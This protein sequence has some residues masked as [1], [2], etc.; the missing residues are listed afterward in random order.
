MSN[1]LTQQVSLGVVLTNYNH[2]SLIRRALT[3]LTQQER[4][5][6]QLIIVDDG[7]R[8]G[9]IE[10]IR[11]FLK[12]PRITLI[13]KKKNEGLAKAV[14]SGLDALQTDLVYFAAA[15]D[16][17]YPKFFQRASH[18]AA[19]H[20]EAA[21][22]FGR[23]I[24]ISWPHST[25]SR[26]GLEDGG[27]PDG[28]GLLTQQD[29]FTRYYCKLGPMSNLSPATIYR[30]WALEAIRYKDLLKDD[31]GF[32]LDSFIVQIIGG[33]YPSYYIDADCVAWTWSKG[34]AKQFF[35]DNARLLK[36]VIGA[37][38][39]LQQEPYTSSLT[40]AH[41]GLYL[42][43]LWYR[44]IQAGF[45]FSPIEFKSIPR[46]ITAL[47][48]AYDIVSK[49]Y[50]A[51]SP[52]TPPL[53]RLVWRVLLGVPKIV[54]GISCRVYQ[55]LRKTVRREFAKRMLHVFIRPHKGGTSSPQTTRISS[56]RLAPVPVAKAEH[57]TISAL[58]CNFNHAKHI[59]SSIEAVIAQT[60]TPDELL[61]MDD[62]STDGSF[63]IM[64]QYVDKYS[65][66]R[67]FK[68]ERNMGYI[69]GISELTRIAKG[70]FIHRGTSDDYMEPYF[71]EKTMEMAERFPTVGVVSTELN[72]F[73]EL[74][75]HMSILEVPWW[76]TGYKSPDEFLH[77]C[78]E[79]TDP[80]AT[81][82]PSTIFRK[83]VVDEV[84]GWREELD[85][86]DVSFV[87]QAAALKYGM[88]YVDVPAYTWVARTRGWTQETNSDVIKAASVCHSYFELM[89]SP[90]FR[91]LFGDIFPE[92]WLR[93]NLQNITDSVFSRI[94]QGVPA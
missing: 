52:H 69:S 33:R 57:K 10:A 84:G 8:D 23:L 88:V 2:G 15:D 6:D 76:G 42:Y 14:L 1:S 30:T 70:E 75:A 45:V 47:A 32:I 21:M 85:T 64:K 81:L 72:V 87:L 48:E 31:F 35:E 79:V 60:R 40:P 92:A 53:N 83:A 20:P 68:R 36:F 37:T 73:H 78:L 4:H 46:N 71:I 22:I 55:A 49:S 62:G 56:N 29:F 89:R 41:Y 9:S 12:D 5:P 17:V 90:Q 74:S 26:L 93:A 77:H 58:I 50:K 66:I 43:G 16:Y 82:A 13:Q 25:E 24:S 86:W 44:A 39:R 67:V 91:S 61:I 3:A 63:E 59:A 51:I 94:V 38:E 18:A 27:A 65:W 19:Q 54:L 7:S 80:R 11:P 28:T 34:G